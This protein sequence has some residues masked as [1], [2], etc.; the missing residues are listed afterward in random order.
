[1]GAHHVIDH[2]ER[3]DRALTAIGF[4]E[5]R[6]IAGLSASDKHREAMVDALAPYGELTLIDDPPSFDIVPFK[7]KNIA[8]H[9]S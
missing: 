1:M 9:W 2:H 4:P 5:V 8:I 3:L 7:M 6:Y